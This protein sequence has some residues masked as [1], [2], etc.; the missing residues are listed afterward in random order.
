MCDSRN[1]AVQLTAAGAAAIAVI[2]LKGPAVREFLARYFS[3][4]VVCRRCIHGEIKDADRIL[5]DAVVVLCD[6]ITAD[7]NVHG[8]TWVVQSVLD[9]ARRTG[10]QIVEP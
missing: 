10:F 2:R 7:V 5:D 9:L 4:P 1:I 3:K 8:G 6:E